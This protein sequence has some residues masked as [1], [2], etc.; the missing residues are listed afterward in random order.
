MPSCRIPGR[1]I[2]SSARSALRTNR[3]TG[4]IALFDKSFLQSLSVDESVWFDHFFYPNVCPLFY[5]ETLSDLTKSVREGRTPEQEVGI[6]ANKFPEMHGTPNIHHVT[7]CTGELLG[8]KVPMTGQMLISGGRP[9]KAAGQTGIVFDKFPEAEA[10]SRWQNREFM[11]VEQL[12]AKKWREMLTN[13]DLAEIANRFK[14]IG[15]DGKN[16]KTLHQA[17]KLA[18]EAVSSSDRPFDRMYLALLFLNIHP[19]YHREILNRWSIMNYAP[20]PSYAPY[21]AYVFTIELFFQ[22]SLAANLISSDRLSNRVDIGYLFYMPFSMIFVSSDKLHKKCAPLFLRPD[23]QFI[24]GPELKDGLKRINEHYMNLS[25]EEKEKGIMAFSSYPP[26]EGDF[27]VSNIWDWHFPGWRNKED[28]DLSK[29][30]VKNEDLVAHLKK[31]TDA[32]T[33]KPDE[34]DFDLSNTDS[35]S[36]SRMV[37]KKKGS[38]FQVPKDLEVDN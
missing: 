15:I 31:F 19:Q 27:L 11:Q 13:M 35:M 22:F 23:Q 30:N 12:F 17:K 20:L 28:I 34:V 1:P 18:V 38:W 5:I 14:K 8:N 9:V 3:S 25:E 26:K 24:W 29:K 10:F 6:I 21:V 37:R 33:L 4:K 32:P 16:C 36:L 2:G 7:A